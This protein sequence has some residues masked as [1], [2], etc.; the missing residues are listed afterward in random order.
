MTSTI[1][2]LSRRPLAVVR[3]SSETRRPVTA[4]QSVASSDGAHVSPFCSHTACVV[5]SRHVPAHTSG[6]VVTSTTAVVPSGA[7][8]PGMPVR[9][10]R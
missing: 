4:D 8:R 5:R 9:T 6:L 3:K 1:S 2:P 10:G 7:V